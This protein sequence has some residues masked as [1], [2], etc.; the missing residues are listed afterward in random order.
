VTLNG[1]S[2]AVLS[3]G[4]TIA[5]TP[6]DERGVV[7]RLGAAD[8][9]DAV[10]G[11]DA[12]GI[13]VSVQDVCRVPSAS[14]TFADVGAAMAAA[15]EHLDGGV[16][17]IVLTQGTD[18]I[19]ET[20]WLLDLLHTGRQPLVVTG[21][22]RNPSLAGADGPANLLAAI[23]VAADPAATGLGC[24][25][26]LADEIHAARWVRK[27]HSTSVAAFASPGRGPIGHLAE[28]M[29]TLW[30][31]PRRLDLPVLDVVRALRAVPATPAVAIVPMALA[32]DGHLLAALEPGIA[33]GQL[34][35]LVI[36]GFGVGHVPATCTELL[37]RIAERIP[38][39]LT[40]RTGAG[41]VATATY[42]F[43]GSESDL[44]DRGLVRGGWLDPYKARILLH[45]LLAAGADGRQVRQ[46]FEEV[47]AGS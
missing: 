35:G 17:G 29:P 42:A 45:L 38:V 31:R 14:L 21:A 46:A 15:R 18:T 30:G 7:P 10:P 36:A 24:L 25:V 22:M 32:D 2:V 12:S 4:G 39:V 19:E 27:T 43:P 34:H 23:Q 28:G 33:A 3:L 11:L 20:G 40:T 5:M 47:R 13:K 6:G 8:L 44:L 26:V 41:P 1:R 9:V 16:D 37:A